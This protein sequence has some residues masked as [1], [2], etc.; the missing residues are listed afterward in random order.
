M[1]M[2]LIC[3]F[4]LQEIRVLF[5]NYYFSFFVK[6]HILV[7]QRFRVIYRGICVY[8][9]KIQVT[10]GIFQ[11]YTTRKSCITIFYHVIENTVTRW[12]GWVWCSWIALIDGKVRGNS[13]EYTTSFLH[14]DW[15]F[16]LWHGEY[17][18]SAHLNSLY[19]KSQFPTVAYLSRTRSYRNIKEETRSTAPTQ[20][21]HRRI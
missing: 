19:L 16:F 3:I 7:M 5:T 1:K 13:D 12:T 4:F 2:K 18:D 10:S 8:T 20:W 6:E 15:L 9:K 11:S 17:P 14:S 21:S